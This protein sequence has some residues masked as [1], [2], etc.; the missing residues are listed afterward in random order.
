MPRGLVLPFPSP[1]GLLQDDVERLYRFTA[2]VP[3][4]QVD[5]LTGRSRRTSAI[6]ALAGRQLRRGRDGEA[7]VV[8]DASGGP[9]SG[10]GPELDDL[11]A[12]LQ[13]AL[14]ATEEPLRPRATSFG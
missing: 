2:G 8:R 1:S 3:G 14:S 12:A 4:A 11:L 7:V 6:I 9:R 10:Q 5:I 13:A